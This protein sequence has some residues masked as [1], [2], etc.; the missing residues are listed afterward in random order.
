VFIS[1][2][3]LQFILLRWYW[4]FFIW[5]RF[6]WQVSRINL[7]LI[8]SHPDRCA[9]LGFLG[10]TSYAFSPVLFA[11]GAMLAGLAASRI[12]YNGESLPS[13][14]LQIFGFVV[15]FVVAILGPLVMF[16]PKM[17]AA[18]RRGLAEYG[19]LAQ[20]YVQ[21]FQNTWIVGEIAPGQELLG[22][23]DIQSLADLGNS[24]G[25]VRDMRVVPFGLDDITR[26]AAVTAAPFIPLLL[27]VWS[28][29]E[30]IMR[31]IKVVF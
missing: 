23:A 31:V 8:P 15:F 16:T 26:L 28:P 25:M 4:R 21:N 14:K 7:N 30:L 3:I 10:K 6:L 1:I 22:S 9:G 11:Q 12:L 24:Y 18:K 20:R 2:P 19:L 27:T 13:F 5:F 17:A 29:E